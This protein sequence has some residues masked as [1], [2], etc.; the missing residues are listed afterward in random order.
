MKP[1]IRNLYRLLNV[2]EKGFLYS[3]KLATFQSGKALQRMLMYKTMC[4]KD[5]S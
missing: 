2:R 3:T 4:A 1:V 5:I